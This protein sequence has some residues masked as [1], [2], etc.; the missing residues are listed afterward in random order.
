MPFPW[1]RQDHDPIDPCPASWSM[2]ALALVQP[3]HAHR[4]RS[5]KDETRW[6][7]WTG[8]RHAPITRSA[9]GGIGRSGRPPA[10]PSGPSVDRSGAFVT[11]QAA[12]STAFAR[13]KH[14]G[15]TALRIWPRER[16][17][18]TRSALDP[19]RKEKDDQT[20]D[21]PRGPGLM[22]LHRHRRQ[23]V[24]QVAF[25]PIDAVR[26]LDSWVGNFGPNI[27]GRNPV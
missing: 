22:I 13:S 21:V 11:S 7:W 26:S 20:G 16:M 12:W 8:R 27:H 18:E 10:P 6:G 9:R 25:R 4:L 3:G 17:A 19:D 1:E 14:S 2:L 15:L 24:D 5:R 23:P